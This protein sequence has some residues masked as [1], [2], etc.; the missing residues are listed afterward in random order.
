MRWWAFSIS[1]GRLGR[2]PPEMGRL[3][4]LAAVVFWG[5]SFV[6]TKQALLELTPLTLIFA[7][8]ALGTLVLQIVLW[9][10]REPLLPPRSELPA[11]ALM[12]FIGVFLHQVLQV[13]GL[14]LTTAVRT[15]W[16]VGLIPIWSAILGAVFLGE[17]LGGRKILG[18]G[19][20]MVGAALVI[21]R[22]EVFSRSL[23]LRATKGDLLV[24]A[25]TFNWAVFSIIG[26]KTVKRLGSVRA[27]AAATFLGWTM[28]IPLFL[29]EHVGPA[30]FPSV[31]VR[32]LVAIAFLGVGCSGFA[33]LFWYVALERL[34]TSE[35]AAFLY[36][37]PL[38]TLAAAVTLLQEPVAA[39]TIAGGVLAM[40]GVAIVQRASTGRGSSGA[41]FRR[42]RTAAGR[43]G[44]IQTPPDEDERRGSRRT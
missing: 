20:G 6:A 10:R 36:L 37:E 28:T 15:G 11:L 3:A 12:G 25:S 18:L 41:R 4:A 1:F 16:L 33:Y 42:E 14:N 39:T 23:D 19:I 38:V 32:T 13:S 40:V 35:V 29:S 34:P 30:V 24:L 26:R 31:S 8:F 9:L 21:T 7:R 27:T 44:R 17:R 2:P 43:T 5:L 22:G